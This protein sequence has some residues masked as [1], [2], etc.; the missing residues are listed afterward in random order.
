MKSAEKARLMG[1][2]TGEALL[3]LETTS[4]K[5]DPIN[6]QILWLTKYL[7]TYKEVQEMTRE[8][9]ILFMSLLIYKVSEA[10][11]VHD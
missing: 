7:K 9:L 2:I 4:I 6:A 5:D 10:R 11:F 1:E 8:D 3:Y